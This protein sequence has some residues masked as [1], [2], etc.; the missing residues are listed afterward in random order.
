LLD[1]GCGVKCEMYDWVKD[2]MASFF[3]S[4]F[5]E[6][7]GKDRDTACWFSGGRHDSMIVLRMIA[8]LSMGWIC[9]WCSV[10]Q[11]FNDMQRGRGQE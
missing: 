7:A 8:W 4:S 11:R 9:G 1:V 10:Q 5:A 3:P 2:K 6:S